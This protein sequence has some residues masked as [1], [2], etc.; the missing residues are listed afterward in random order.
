MTPT[1]SRPHTGRRCA[2]EHG[3][4]LI[5]MVVGIALMAL[6]M[7]LLATSLGLA[8]QA[9]AGLTRATAVLPVDSAQS[10]LRQ[11]VAGT[12]VTQRRS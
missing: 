6:L 3:F 10:Y 9:L 11:L 1:T 7:A 5:E 12:I 2:G 4:T 8:R